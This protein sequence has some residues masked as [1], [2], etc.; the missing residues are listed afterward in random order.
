MF[1]KNIKVPIRPDQVEVLDSDLLKIASDSMMKDVEFHPDFVYLLIR[2]MS[3]G[4]YWG[5]NNNVDFFEELELKQSYQTFMDAKVFKNHENKEVEKALGDVISSVWND[6]MKCV[7]LVIRIDKVIAPTITRGFLTGTITDVSMGCR[8]DHVVC[9]YCGNKAK[10]RKDY[11]E[12]LRDHSLRGKI[13]ENGVKVYE[14]N[15]GP[16]FHDISVVNKGAD[17]TAK[18]FIVIDG[19]DGLKK[20]ASESAQV[21]AN[22]KVADVIAAMG[23]E[24]VASDDIPNKIFKLASD[25]ILK[26]AEIDKIIKGNIMGIVN[27]EVEE[28]DIDEVFGLV[29]LLYTDFMDKEQLDEFSEGVR[30]IAHRNGMDIEDVFKTLVRTAELSGIEFSPCEYSALTNNLFGGE[31]DPY[32]YGES[33]E[34]IFDNASNKVIIKSMRGPVGG[35]MMVIRGRKIS[36]SEIVRERKPWLE[37]EIFNSLFSDMM[38]SRSYHPEFSIPRLIRIIKDDVQPIAR[39]RTHFSIPVM[40]MLKT[41]S[42]QITKEAGVYSVYQDSRVELFN[43]GDFEKYAGDLFGRDIEIVKYAGKIKYLAGVATAYPLS[44]GY[45]DYQ[46]SR[47]MNG[48]RVGTFN[49]FMAENPKSAFGTMVALQHLGAKKGLPAIRNAFKKAKSANAAKKVILNAAKAPKAS[50]EVFKDPSRWGFMQNAE[51][52]AT[53]FSPVGYGFEKVAG[54][55]YFIENE[56]ADRLDEIFPGVSILENES[57]NESMLGEYTPEQVDAIRVAIVTLFK[58]DESKALDI[59]TAHGLTD[60]D[61][62]KYLHKSANFITMELEKIANDVM[63][64]VKNGL[65][66][67]LFRPVKKGLGAMSFGPGTILDGVITT[68]LSKKTKDDATKK[69]DLIKEDLKNV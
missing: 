62:G 52:I 2:A 24:K 41:A 19:K 5:E 50:S 14:I 69:D 25:P 59:L 44:M 64:T 9:S 1:Y 37:Q 66:F 30:K 7:D 46:R 43:S 13:M 26:M 61:I 36:P 48:E 34:N 35:G 33:V 12:H 16:K 6:D 15:K 29:R 53:L 55:P 42:D 58:G 21:T 60:L 57:I 4:E 63:D 17:R 10:T 27:S 49:R 56:M 3:A 45:S 11:C 20:T 23:I 54:D 65:S 68:K 38:P 22:T 47:M 39:N 28:N 40:S 8:V 31:F 18:A 67:S 51:K 32:G